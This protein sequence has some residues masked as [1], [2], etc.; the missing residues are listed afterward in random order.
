MNAIVL[1]IAGAILLIVGYYLPPAPPP[2]KLIFTVIGWICVAVGL[3]LLLALLLGIA[4]A[5]PAR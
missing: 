1:L 4:V 3:I 5:L 2:I